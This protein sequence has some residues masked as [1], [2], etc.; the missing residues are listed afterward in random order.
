MWNIL[1]SIIKDAAKDSLGVAIGTSK[2][3]TSH[4]ESWWLCEEVQS[5]V[6]KKQAR[7]KKLLT[8]QE[9]NLEEQLRAQE[10]YN[11]NKGKIKENIA[12]QRSA[13][14]DVFVPLSEPL[15]AVVL[16]GTEGT[17]NVVSATSGATTTLSI[18][19]ASAS[20]IAPIFVDDYEVLDAE[21]QAVTDRN[22]ASF[23]NIDD[24][25]LNII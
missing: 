8:Y 12:N 14:H 16:I 18:T 2:T 7:F 15:P 9:G 4:S 1:A 24:A 13:L 3:H 23:P 22:A 20:I 10:R 11:H 25:E 6:S 21:D 17:S 19:F 5:K